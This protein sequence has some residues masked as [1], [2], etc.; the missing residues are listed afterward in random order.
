MSIFKLKVDGWFFLLRTSDG[1]KTMI[2]DKTHVDS[3]VRF[4]FKDFVGEFDPG[5]GRTLAV[6][7]MHAS[8]AKLSGSLLLEMTER[9]TGE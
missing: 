9:R 8:W 2:W 4:E 6:R 3:L 5:S 7:L 1:L